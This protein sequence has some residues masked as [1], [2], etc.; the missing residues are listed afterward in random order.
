MKTGA[1]IGQPRRRTWRWILGTALAGILLYF[2]LRGVEW[3]RVWQIIAGARWG[4]LAAGCAITCCSFF[5]RSL[6]WRILLNA[7]ESLG[8]AT[9]FRATMAGYLGNAFLPARA[10]E[11]VRTVVISSGSS[12]TK[13]YVLTTALCERLMD[14][15]TL[16]LWSSLI[17][18]GVSPKPRW[19][20]DVSR[21]TAVVAA[22]GALAIA[23]LPH[24][25]GLI[26]HL[27]Q[28]FPLPA[29]LRA[30]LLALVDQVLL[31]VRAF[32]HVRRFLSFAALTGAIW[33]LDAFAI[34]VGAYGLGLHI[35]FTVAMLLL[36]GMG[37]GSALPSTPGYVG[38]YQFVAVTVLVPFGIGR[39]AALAYI[40]TAQALSY[41]VILI[42]GVPGLYTLRRTAG[43]PA[44]RKMED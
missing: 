1:A 36:T 10:G 8:V 44:L 7:E 30:R 25:G 32:H 2:S 13:T 27:L 20:E 22:A 35:S 43:L 17:L 40:L 19:M 23:L 34:M 26:Q 31:G 14:A 24:T 37:L 33:I 41:V 42:L 9:V 6:R 4:F 16:V 21:T 12:L 28:R 3:R 15:I 18:L 38:I 39:D 11:L 5:T 29:A